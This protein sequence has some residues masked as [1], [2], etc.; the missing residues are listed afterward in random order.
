MIYICD[1]KRHLICNPYIIENLH[2][3]AKDLNIKR[4][5]YHGG[6]YP[7]YDIPKLRMVEI[8]RR[9]FVVTTKQLFNIIKLHMKE[10]SGWKPIYT[11][12]NI[13]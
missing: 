2:K 5:W 8:M 3:M 9:S 10:F 6:K 11:N 4:C 1:D 12:G 7:H 13:L